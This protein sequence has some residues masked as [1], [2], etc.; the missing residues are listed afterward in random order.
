MPSAGAVGSHGNEENVGRK[1]DI[2]AALAGVPEN[3]IPLGERAGEVHL[4]HGVMGGDRAHEAGTALKEP[5]AGKIVL[6]VVG[7]VA[8]TGDPVEMAHGDGFAVEVNEDFFLRVLRAQCAI[9]GEKL[10]SGQFGPFLVKNLADAAV[11]P[12]EESLAGL[13]RGRVVEVAGRG[14]VAAE[15]KD[16]GETRI[17]VRHIFKFVG[18]GLCCIEADRAVGEAQQKGRKK[19]RG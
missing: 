7:V 5:V 12:L 10:V 8:I 9:G 19:G 4:E 6:E 11:E 1:G 3:I 14:I 16:L 15:K 2:L 17:R 18:D 13:W